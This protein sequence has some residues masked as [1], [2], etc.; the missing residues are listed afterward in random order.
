[1]VLY[2]FKVR[3]SSFLALRTEWCSWAVWAYETSLPSNMTE[4]KSHSHI[5]LAGQDFI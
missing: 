3:T 4:L 5:V 2:R 1:M